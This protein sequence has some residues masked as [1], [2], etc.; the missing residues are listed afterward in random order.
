MSLKRLRQRRQGALSFIV[1]A[2]ASG[3]LFVKPDIGL[4]E[5]KGSFVRI[6]AVQCTR[7]FAHAAN[8]RS[9]EPRCGDGSAWPM[10]GKGRR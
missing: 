4:R 10:S 2:E 3:C 1:A 9:N 7:D 6:P 8:G 5:A